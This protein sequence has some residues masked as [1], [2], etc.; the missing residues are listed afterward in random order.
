MKLRRRPRNYYP[1]LLIRVA[2]ASPIV[3]TK[4]LLFLM[5]NRSTWSLNR[6]LSNL[7]IQGL[8][9]CPKGNIQ[10]TFEGEET[11][12]SQCSSSSWTFY[13]FFWEQLYVH[14]YT[15]LQPLKIP[16]SRYCT[17]C[18]IGSF[19]VKKILVHLWVQILDFC[20]EKLRYLG[21][22]DFYRL[23]WVEFYRYKKCTFWTKNGLLA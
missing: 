8:S 3:V 16:F 15:L 5:E 17:H 22:L 10:P 23:G 14:S 21:W 6:T 2:E 18:A 19:F 1:K 12:N 13:I 9:W 4:V 20:H 11:L 7:T